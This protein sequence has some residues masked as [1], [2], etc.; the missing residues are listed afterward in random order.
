MCRPEWWPVWWRAIPVLL[1]C[2]LAATRPV[3]GNEPTAEELKAR[4]ATANT[5]DKVRL[6]VQVAEKQLAE[7]DRLYADGD[8]EKGQTALTDV[9]SFAE[10][11]RD[12]SIESKKHQKQTEIAVRGMTRKLNDILHT[13]GRGDQAAVQQAINRL[14]RVRDDLLASMFPKGAQ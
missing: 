3:S 12:Y 4:I 13:L 1:L 14:E 10:L 8:I 2:V 9:A 11:A 7:A 5:G 6:C